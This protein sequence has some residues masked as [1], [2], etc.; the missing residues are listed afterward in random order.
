MKTLQLRERAMSF[1]HIFA[2]FQACLFYLCVSQQI[3]AFLYARISAAGLVF[4]LHPRSFSL[5]LAGLPPA[6]FLADILSGV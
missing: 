4:R 1:R 2:E 6:L 3:L 5:V